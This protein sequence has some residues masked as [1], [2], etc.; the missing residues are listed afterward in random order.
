MTATAVAAIVVA[1]ASVVGVVLLA[2]FLARLDR[3]VR[4]VGES[5]ERLRFTSVPLD[6]PS[7]LEAGGAPTR[8]STCPIP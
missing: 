6:A 2:V 7:E 8:S 3:T 4:S 5:V 1:G